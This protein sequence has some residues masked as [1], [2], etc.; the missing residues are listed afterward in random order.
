METNLTNTIN[1]G[2]VVQHLCRDIVGEVIKD[3]GSSVTIIDGGFNE[4][5]IGQIDVLKSEIEIISE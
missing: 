2:D 1:I 4:T 3:N 5:D